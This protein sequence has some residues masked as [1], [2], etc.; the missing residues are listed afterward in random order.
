MPLTPELKKA[1][2]GSVNGQVV[3]A[4]AEK[5]TI[6]VVVN[7]PIRP[8]MISSAIK[9]LVNAGQLSRHDALDYIMWMMDEL[10]KLR[11]ELYE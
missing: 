6:G 4:S 11:K 2:F 3:G 5:K 7:I 1:L 10:E 9:Q 8:D